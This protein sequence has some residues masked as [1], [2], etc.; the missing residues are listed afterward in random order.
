MRKD[1]LGEQAAK[2]AEV[3]D[4]P[5]REPPA[6]RGVALVEDVGIFGGCKTWFVDRI[7]IPQHVRDALPGM[8]WLGSEFTPSPLIDPRRTFLASLV[9]AS[10][11]L[12]DKAFSNKA[13]AKLSGLEALEVGKCERAL[14]KARNRLS[15]NRTSLLIPDTPVRDPGSIDRRALIGVGE[16]ATPRWTVTR[17]SRATSHGQHDPN[18]HRANDHHLQPHTPGDMPLSLWTVEAIDT[19]D[20]DDGRLLS[21]KFPRTAL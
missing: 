9:L 21:T 10:K 20:S 15:F 4:D 14:V 5:S 8:D 11:F 12:L 2:V 19:S 1:V 16:L 17:D 3:E 6:H 18:A 13:W 7:S